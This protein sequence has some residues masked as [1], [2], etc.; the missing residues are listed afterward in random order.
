M[1]SLVDLLATRVAAGLKRSSVKSCSRWSE[2]YRVMGN[3]Y[4]GSWSFRHHPWLKGMCDD[5][6]EIVVGQK[7]AQMGYTEWALN[8]TFYWIDCLGESVLYILPSDSDASDFS[9]SRFDP[10]LELSE[11][12]QKL[13]SDVRNVGH[14]RAGSANLFVRGSRS[15]SKLKSLPVGGLIFDEVDEMMQDNIALALE[16]TSGQ[17]FKRYRYLSTPTIDG[18]GINQQYKNSTQ[19]HYFFKCPHCDKFIE[20]TFPDCLII[21]ATDLLDA[22]IKDSHIICPACKHILDHKAK[23]DFLSKGEHVP[24]YTDRPIKG[25]HISQLYS[26]TLEPAN[27]AASYLRAQTNPADEQ[28]FFN[29]KLGLTHTVKGGKISDAQI[30]ECIGEF[31]T[32]DGPVRI[33]RI[34]TMGTDVGTYLHICIYEWAIPSNVGF[35]DVNVTAKPTLIWYGKRKDFTDLDALMRQYKVHYHV[36]DAN[37][38][39]REAIKHAQRCEGYVKLCFYGNGLSGHRIHV[40]DASLYTITVDRSSWLDLAL[41]RYH[42]NA[43]SLPKDLDLEFRAHLKEPTRIY[44]KDQDGN[45][46]SKYVNAS[47]DHYAHASNYAEIALQMAVSNG[48]NSDIVSPV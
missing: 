18:F 26:C 24:T 45:P 23:P 46:I 29:S 5:D 15:R 27:L 32:S 10:A 28:E 33:N 30:A 31:T 37:P 8:T 36:I 34:R 2:S 22:S 39:R 4:P 13:F 35:E 12:L 43:I 11:H 47:D 40:H 38:E 20:L 19:N 16:R 1:H 9:A 3:P 42:H 44:K 41:G 7:A 14:K 17:V 21:T 6:S 48:Y 25:Y